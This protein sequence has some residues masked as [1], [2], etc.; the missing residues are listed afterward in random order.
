MVA[1]DLSDRRD[2]ELPQV[3]R[4]LMEDPETGAKVEV[5]T[6]DERFRNRYAGYAEDDRRKWE[7]LLRRGGAGY[8]AVP[9][10][11][12]VVRVLRRYMEGRA[13]KR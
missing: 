9:S 13:L 8:M 3:G 12:D 2:A 11:A 5:D 4:V 10:D 7:K 1:A 6:R